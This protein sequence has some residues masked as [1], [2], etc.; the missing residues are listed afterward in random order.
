VTLAETV[1]LAN[2]V[3]LAKTGTLGT[4]P[5]PPIT[6]A[7]RISGLAATFWPVLWRYFWPAWARQRSSPAASRRRKRRRLR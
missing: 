3:M 4:V 1:T 5:R 7:A 2:T 6:A